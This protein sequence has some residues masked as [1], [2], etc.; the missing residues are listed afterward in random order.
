MIDNFLQVDLSVW[1]WIFIIL[2]GILTGVINTL[3]GSGSLITLPIFIFLC[4]L[5]AP[6]AN[7]TNRI[8][9]LFQSATAVYGF[10]KSGSSNFKGAEWLV[11]PAIIGAALG[12]WIATTLDKEAM[13]RAIG[14][15]MLFM[16]VVLIINPKRWIRES[17]A[18][19]SQNKKPLSIF[20]FFIIG[21]YGGFIQAGVGIMLL[22]GLVLMARYS[23]IAANSIKLLIVLLFNIPVLAIFL[24]YHQVHIGWGV[25]MAI[26]QSIGAVLGVRFASKVPNANIWIHRLLIVI[27]CISAIKFLGIYDLLLKGFPIQN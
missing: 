12:A 11:I 19:S 1:E 10:W 17:A 3:A 16:L 22:A 2:A 27:V 14:F 25:V 18:S 4:G 5:P 7:G 15:L 26:C 20:V 8:G 6:V 23:L 9:A 21:I 24:W 13:F